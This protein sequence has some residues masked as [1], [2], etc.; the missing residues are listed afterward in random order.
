MNKHE[1]KMM[2]VLIAH[3]GS[4][5]RVPMS[6][7]CSVISKDLRLLEFDAGCCRQELC[8][9]YLERY[10][11]MSVDTYRSIKANIEGMKRMMRS[12][13]DALSSLGREEDIKSLDESEHE[14]TSSDDLPIHQ[15][16]T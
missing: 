6:E 11:S 8:E 1:N 16:S 3:D 13:E 15:A 5:N 12:V 10:D 9:Q 14:Q 7:V 4:I 2:G